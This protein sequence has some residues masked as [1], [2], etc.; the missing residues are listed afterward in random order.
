MKTQRIGVCTLVFDKTGKKVLLGKRKNNYK[1]GMYGMPGGRL[2]LKESVISC[3]K[4]ELVEETG[5]RINSLV[6][7]GVIREVQESNNYIHF[8]FI[9]GDYTGN[10]KLTEPDRCEGWQWYPLDKLPENIL[11]GHLAA[12]NLYKKSDFQGYKDLYQ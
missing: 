10:P 1:A 5:L 8:A 4:R 7:L 11:P 3:A 9:C 12:I 6:Y 2:E